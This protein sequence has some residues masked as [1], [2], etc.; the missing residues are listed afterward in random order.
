[1]WVMQKNNRMTPPHS[2][3]PLLGSQIRG[4][5]RAAREE[6]MVVELGGTGGARGTK[7]ICCHQPKR[8]SRGGAMD[9]GVMGW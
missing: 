7:G 6:K 5:G 2:D 9:G 8:R 1:M 3:Y 4:G